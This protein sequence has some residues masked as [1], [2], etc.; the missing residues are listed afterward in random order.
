MS[1][2]VCIP[3]SHG[4]HITVTTLMQKQAARAH[5]RKVKAVVPHDVRKCE[6]G[7]RCRFV[8]SD[9]L[10][11][12]LNCNDENLLYTNTRRPH[13]RGGCDFVVTTLQSDRAYVYEVTGGAL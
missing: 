6:D 11:W 5:C 13:V 10:S 2:V 7:P 8:L 1:H 12:E 9:D 3:T 4:G